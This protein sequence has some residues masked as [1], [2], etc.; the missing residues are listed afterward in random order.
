MIT[1]H[2]FPFFSLF[3]FFRQ[4][5]NLSGAHSVLATLYRTRAHA[6]ARAI[7]FIKK[8][9]SY[10]TCWRMAYGLAYSYVLYRKL[11]LVCLAVH[12]IHFVIRYG[13]GTC[14]I[15][16]IPT[17]VD[18]WNGR[19]FFFVSFFFCIKLKIENDPTT[20][21]RTRAYTYSSN[22]MRNRFEKKSH[23]KTIW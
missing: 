22:Q 23:F 7:L 20:L 3:L 10:M 17:C 9:Y 8:V 6:R 19:C 5:W 16:T 14:H 11:E 12:S 13:M 4:N 15:F 2:T 1:L 21:T 18:T